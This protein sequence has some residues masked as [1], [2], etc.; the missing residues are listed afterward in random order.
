[1]SPRARVYAL[2]GAA[3]VVAGGAAAGVVL[4]IGGGSGEAP[5]R[6]R[7]TGNPPLELDLGVRQDREAVALREA[8]R[9]YLS[10]RRG[11]AASIFDRHRS[12]QARVGASMAGPPRQRV[13][14]LRS[15]ARHHPASA[16][17]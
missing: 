13:G 17:V 15:E 8:Q 16:V 3:C 12:L 10:G 6:A 9:L 4:A 11:Q 7:L 14:R 5:R 1:M 2:V